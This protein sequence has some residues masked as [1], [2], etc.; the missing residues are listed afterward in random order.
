MKVVLIGGKSSSTPI[1]YNYLNNHIDFEAVII[2]EKVPAKQLLRRRLKKLGYMKVIGQV[3]FQLFVVK[4]LQ[5]KSKRRIQDILKSNKLDNTPISNAKIRNVTS[6]NSEETIL[7]LNKIAPDIIIVNGTRIISKKVLDAVPSIFMNMHVGITPGYRGVHGAYWALVN[8]DS[9]NAGVTI[10]YVDQGI[11]TGKVIAQGAIEITK[12]ENFATY[13]YLQT[14]K[15]LTLM[16]EAINNLKEG[17]KIESFPKTTFSKL[18]THPTIWEYFYYYV[19]K[20]V[21]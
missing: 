10:H 18:W 20:G 17:K 3:L 13:P 6:V 21:K 1:V 9:S 16:L 2:E 11:D 14:A 12:R 5:S 15:G 8:N 7:I 19:S 4:A